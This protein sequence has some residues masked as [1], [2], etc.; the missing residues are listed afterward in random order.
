M[1]N[2]QCPNHACCPD[3]C[4]AHRQ[5]TREPLHRLAAIVTAGMM[6]GASRRAPAAGSAT[7]FHDMSNHIITSVS[8]A[9]GLIRLGCGGGLLSF[10]FI[11]AAMQGSVS[12]GSLTG[13]KASSVGLDSVSVFA[14]P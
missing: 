11:E 4:H 10:P 1:K 2:E 9:N 12:D 14:A 8:G 3:R 7:D 13:I 5:K 6:T